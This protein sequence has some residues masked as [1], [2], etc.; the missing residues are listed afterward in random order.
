MMTAPMLAGADAYTWPYVASVEVHIISAKTVEYVLHMATTVVDDSSVTPNTLV[1]TVRT[2]AGKTPHGTPNWA[3]GTY[4]R[5]RDRTGAII[6]AHERLYSGQLIDY[7]EDVA[8]ELSS[9][10]GSGTLTTTNR[11]MDDGGECV[12]TGMWTYEGNQTWESFVATDLWNGGVLGGC[13]GIPPVDQW[14]ALKTP[15]VEIAYGTL[16]LKDAEGSNKTA[17]VTVEC[18]TGMKYTLRLQ[19]ANNETSLDNGGRV[20]WK[21]GGMAMGETLTGEAG[22]N[23]VDLTA[24]LHGPFGRTGEFHGSGILFVSYP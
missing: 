19:D 2:A 22:E 16:T 15:T 1:H 20:T 6:A 24:T 14:C 9:M 13:L 21:A 5:Y 17:G 11:R 12:G 4:R 8:S 7:V 3:W 23:G 18:T 10:Y